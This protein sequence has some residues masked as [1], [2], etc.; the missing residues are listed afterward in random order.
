MS[1]HKAFDNRCLLKRGVVMNLCIG[2]LANILIKCALPGVNNQQ[3]LSTLV[4][5][6]EHDNHYI[7]NEDDGYNVPNISNLMNCKTNFPVNSSATNIVSLARNVNVND[8]KKKF[9]V[10]IQLLDKDKRRAAVGALYEVISKD[11]LLKEKHQELF[12]QCMGNS[13]EKILNSHRVDLAKFLAGIF[14]YTV[15]TNDNKTNRKDVIKISKQNFVEQF[16]EYDVVFCQNSEVGLPPGWQYPEGLANYMK[17][18]SNKYNYIPSILQSEAFTPFCD[19]YVPNNVSRRV[20]DAK[21]KYT[22]YRETIPSIT[23]DKVL[24]ISHYIIFTGAGGLGKSMMMKNLLLS[25]V[26]EYEQLGFI[27]FF[28]ALKDYDEGYASIVEYIHEKLNSTWPEADI[29]TIEAILEHGMALLLFDG[30]DE[31]NTTNLVD[32]T[33]KLNKFIM[34]YPENFFIVSSRPYSNFQSLTG[35]SL[36]KLEPFTKGQALDLID[37]YSYFEETPKVQKKFRDLLDQKLYYTH[38]NFSDNPL[39]LSIM[40]LT[41][42]MDAEIPT[43]KYKFYDL[44]YEVLSRR[45]DATKD[46]YIR[47]L[48][49][50]WNADQFA[51]CFSYF[52]AASYTDSKMSFS[53]G[54]LEHYFMRLQNRVYDGKLRG[55]KIEDVEHVTSEQFAYDVTNNLCLMYREGLNYDFIHRSFQEYF[56]ARYFHSLLDKKLQSIIPMFDKNDLTKKND[57]TLSMLFDMKADAVENYVIIPYLQNLIN[58]CENEYGLWTFLETIYPS[59]QVADGE[60]EVDE[61]ACSPKSNLYSFVHDCYNIP[62]INVNIDDFPDNYTLIIDE[63]LWVNDAEDLMWKE[64]FHNWLNEQEVEYGYFL[65]SEYEEAETESRGY[66][67]EFNWFP[68]KNSTHCELIETIEAEDSPFMKEYDAIKALLSSLQKKTKQNLEDLDIV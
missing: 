7:G 45:H 4:E 58:K 14:L 24:D 65:H 54:D 11:I 39:L 64:E 29:E 38:K 62:E 44:A 35:F 63:L 42:K 8:L 25:C 36:L 26:E 60:A 53:P 30:L 12:K 9:D 18:V 32:F 13:V 51:L 23:L 10:V 56:C 33:K 5:T 27:P 3:M 19:Y 57:M 52:C 20:R 6:I 16:S 67:Y 17:L 68:I 15:L 41:F 43:E 59:Y 22:F 2:I 61:E 28:V 34:K 31:I 46:S 66:V 40:M 55:I 48:S 50:G 47:H 49:T 21:K 37:R 1:Y